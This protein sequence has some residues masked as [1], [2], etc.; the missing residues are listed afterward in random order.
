MSSRGGDVAL[1][2]TYIGARVFGGKAVTSR[3]DCGNTEASFANAPRVDG[4]A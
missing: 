3:R 2:R 4:G 1:D